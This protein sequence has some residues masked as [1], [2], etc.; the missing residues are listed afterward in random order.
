M[1]ETKAAAV[2]IP[3]NNK[4][5]PVAWNNCENPAAASACASA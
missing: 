2:P 1:P 3:N 4:K 5:L